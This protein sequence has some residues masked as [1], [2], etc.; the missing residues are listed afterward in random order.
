MIDGQAP[1]RVVVIAMPGLGP[2]DF[3]IALYSF[4]FAPYELVV[5][6]EGPVEEVLAKSVVVP[7]AGLE[8][9]ETADTVIVPGHSP[10]TR[11]P[12]DNVIAGLRGARARGARIASISTGTFTLGYAGLLDGHQAT[13]HWMH[14]ESLA[15]TFPKAD[16]RQDVLY[17]VSGQLYTSAGAASGIDMFLKMVRSDLGAAV[18]NQRRRR[19]V[20]PPPRSGDQQQF[21]ETFV[22]HPDEEPVL[23]TRAWSLA[24]LD[25]PLTLAQL[26]ARANMSTRNFSRRFVA[27]IGET[28]M[29]WLR[30]ARIDYACELLESTDQNIS[31]VARRCGLGTRANFGRIFAQYVGVHPSEYRVMHR[32]SLNSPSRSP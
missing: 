13:T 7:S 25:E 29:K 32:P 6:G 21:Y 12:S 20:A 31:D 10:A 27:E 22:P 1:H 2:L 24:R 19:L 11:R 28:P 4:G 9:L 16:I 3:G 30:N 15:E 5:C 8:A 23:A 18:A 17:V 26:A 14:L